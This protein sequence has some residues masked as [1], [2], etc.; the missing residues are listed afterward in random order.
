VQKEVGP[1]RISDKGVS[2]GHK[3]LSVPFE[4]E[5]VSV[6]E[7]FGVGEVLDEF[8]PEGRPR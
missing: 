2:L 6:L 8:E 4:D 1:L 5:L 3:L 7:T